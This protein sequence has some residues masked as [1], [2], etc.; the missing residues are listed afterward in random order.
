MKMPIIADNRGDVLAFDSVPKAEA[1][2]EPIDILNG[3]YVVYD[4]EGYILK[5]SVVKDKKG[6]ERV[7]LGPADEK[8]KDEEKLRTVLV[9]FLSQVTE[10]NQPLESFSL[11]QLVEMLAKFKTE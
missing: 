2:M 7:L 11:G 3:E 8:R 9:Q 1:Y 6:R 4:S 10:T 5:P